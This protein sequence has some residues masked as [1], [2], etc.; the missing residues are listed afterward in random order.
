LFALVAAVAVASTG[1]TAPA[2]AAQVSASR[3][4]VPASA[5]ELIVVSSATY[6]PPGYLANFR[7]F[8]RANA[9]SPWRAVFP[10]WRAEIGSG[11]LRNVRGEGDH[12]TPTGVYGV[13]LTMYGIDPNPGGLNYAYHQ[14]VCGDWWDEDPYSSQYN[15]FV[16]V[17]CGSTPSFAA[18]SEALW[19]E[20]IAYPYFAV[21]DY[22][23]DPT[24]SGADAP[25]SG[26]FLHAWMGAPT[27]GCVALTIPELLRV[28]RWLDPV[29]HPVIEIGT[30]AEI[31][32]VPPSSV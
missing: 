13:G 10:A 25:G 12:A 24:I 1:A 31:G 32:H 7:T 4:A 29:D 11:D 17:A 18:W 21:I 8:A 6:D 3:F 28:L 15:E 9:S 5:R 30:D 26:I 16:P 19:T 2:R 14:L 20:T 23:M 27:E 22:N